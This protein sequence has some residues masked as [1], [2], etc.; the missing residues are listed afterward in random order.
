MEGESNKFSIISEIYS[1]FSDKNKE[2]LIGMAKNLLKVQRKDAET[3]E[4]YPALRVRVKNREN[5]AS[6]GN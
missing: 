5:T 2:N 1:Q 4:K 3:I 6:G